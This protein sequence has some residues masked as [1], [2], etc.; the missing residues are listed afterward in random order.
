LISF[1]RLEHVCNNQTGKVQR[2]ARA[3]LLLEKAELKQQI[4][5]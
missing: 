3:D 1:D 4:G 5:G 2:K